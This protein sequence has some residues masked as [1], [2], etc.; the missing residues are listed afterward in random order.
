MGTQKTTDSP[1][2]GIGAGASGNDRNLLRD[3]HRQYTPSSTDADYEPLHPLLYSLDV[4]LP[5]VN[6]LRSITGGPSR[7]LR[8]NVP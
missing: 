4:F 5:F 6:L 2:S 7:G 8:A 1:A 3:L